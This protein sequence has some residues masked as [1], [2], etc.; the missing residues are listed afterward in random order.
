MLRFRLLGVPVLVQPL[1]WI[2]AV[3]L[4]LSMFPQEPRALLVW[5]PN[6]F[7]AILVHEMGHA[8]TGRR[9]GLDPE[10][11]LLMLGGRT[12][13]TSGRRL[14][15]GPSMLVSFAGPAIGLVLGG[16]A[17]WA[18][19]HVPLPQSQYVGWAL[20][21]FIFTNL[22]WA[23]FNLVPIVGLDGGNIMAAFL[24]KFLGAR[25]IRL[26]HL[27]SVV[28]AV[29]V[30]TFFLSQGNFVMA[31]FMGLLA[32]DN[33]QRWQIASMWNEGMRTQGQARPAARPTTEAP[34]DKP[35]EP[36]IQ[37]AFEA[38]EDG[39][40]AQVRRIAEGLVPRIKTESQRFDVAHLVAWG[41]LLGGDPMGA[42]R[43]LRQLMPLGRRPDAL[44]EG[45]LLLDLGQ[46]SR[47]VEALS[48]ALEGR[49]DDFVASRLARAAARASEV[50]PIVK[51]LGKAQVELEARPF[52]IVVAELLRE[53][54]LEPAI[55]LGSAV[56]ERFS[57]GTD[58]F[59]VACAHARLSH[60]DDASR[61]LERA[62][63]AGL[64][65]PKVLLSDD[66]LRSLRERPEFEPLRARI[67]TPPT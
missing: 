38:L 5:V 59:N 49:Q 46:E 32:I 21:S 56:F 18:V 34:S 55:A 42:E 16:A 64:P 24:D 35:L 25:G 13:W 1:F 66:D 57:V 15:P 43:A 40:H 8:L 61:W 7:F 20:L 27:L 44:L 4:G 30:A 50:G 29:A 39:N 53:S 9:F 31:L 26:A 12:V 37:R 45:A 52:Q 28:V 54:V 17:Y 6:V 67:E 65:D 62:L 11:H 22:G 48:E 2:G 33:Y 63:G 36:E 10:V 51:L 14:T 58:A 19:D 60:F 23:L 41:R 3:M 47:A